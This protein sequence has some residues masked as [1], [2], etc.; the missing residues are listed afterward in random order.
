MN[1]TQKRRKQKEKLLLI[2]CASMVM[3][4]VICF[5]VWQYLAHLLVSQ[6]AAQRWQGEGD[7]EFRQVGRGKATWSFARL[8]ASCPRTRRSS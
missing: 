7:M 4:A 5:G 1:S 8:P 3:A 6:Q 2:I